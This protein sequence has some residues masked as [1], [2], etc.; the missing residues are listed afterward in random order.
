MNQG[1]R[2]FYENT[3]ASRGLLGCSYPLSQ[4]SNPRDI[5]Y[6]NHHSDH[7]TRDSHDTG[8]HGHHTFDNR[9]DPSTVGN[10]RVGF[11]NSNDITGNCNNTTGH[12]AACHGHGSI[13]KRHHCARTRNDHCRRAAA[14]TSDRGLYRAR[15]PMD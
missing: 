6:H 5:Y 9:C 15:R 12:N 1:I 8:H 7:T 14:G 3:R 13:S 11:S 10:I 4:R 2:N